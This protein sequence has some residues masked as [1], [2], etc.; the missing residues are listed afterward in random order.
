GAAKDASLSG[1][2]T[3]LSDALKVSSEQL[4]EQ[5]VRFTHLNSI[6]RT[7]AEG[8]RY[9]NERGKPPEN[10]DA[11]TAQALAAWQRQRQVFLRMR[12][13]KEDSPAADLYAQKIPP[14]IALIGPDRQMLTAGRQ[15]ELVQLDDEKNKVQGVIGA[16]EA[17]IEVKKKSDIEQKVHAKLR[18]AQI[19]G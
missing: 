1:A 18:E 14:P 6:V 17:E 19:L 3:A 10:M 5:I 2:Y 12:G 4:G 7:L 8:L 9:L 15:A 11:E 16:L 13:L